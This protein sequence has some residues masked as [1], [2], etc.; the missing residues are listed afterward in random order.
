MAYRV[1]VAATASADADA[2]YEWIARDS[3]KRAI[4]W[5]L[6]L[7]DMMDSLA[8]NPERCPLAPEAEFLG[9][10]VRELLYGSR[11]SAYRVLFSITGDTVSIL[12]VRH[13]ARRSLDEK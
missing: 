8:E 12:Y 10:D 1:E 6:G 4:K 13:G 3:V 11:R 9:K 2:A 7:L 5:Y